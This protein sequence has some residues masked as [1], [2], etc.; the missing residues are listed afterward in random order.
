MAVHIAAA[1]AYDVFGGGLFCV[2]FSHSVS[3]VG[4]EI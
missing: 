4:Y 3:L 1:Y 2:V